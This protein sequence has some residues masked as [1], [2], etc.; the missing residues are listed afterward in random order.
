ME[1]EFNKNRPTPEN[2]YGF[3]CTKGCGKSK[4]STYG[5]EEIF[6]GRGHWGSGSTNKDQ[7]ASHESFVNINSEN[8]NINI[9]DHLEADGVQIDDPFPNEISEKFTGNVCKKKHEVDIHPYA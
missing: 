7:T 1:E 4:Y 6:N 2:V 5:L 3:H 8:V 9:Q